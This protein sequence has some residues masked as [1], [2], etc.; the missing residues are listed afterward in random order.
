[1][2]RITRFVGR[3]HRF[4]AVDSLEYTKPVVNPPAFQPFT[5]IQPQIS[6]SMRITNLSDL[7]DE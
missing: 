5:S 4:V 6:S 3:Y 7:T 2:C 1:M